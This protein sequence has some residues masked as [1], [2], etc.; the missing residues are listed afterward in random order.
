MGLGDNWCSQLALGQPA[1]VEQ[2]VTTHFVVDATGGRG[3]YAR[4]MG[5]RAACKLS[6]EA[7]V[8]HAAE[9]DA[10]QPDATQGV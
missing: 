6:S 1:H 5:A 3:T 7:S 9:S 10:T 2:Q 8:R 4:A